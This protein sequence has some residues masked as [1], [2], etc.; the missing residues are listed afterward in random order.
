MVHNLVGISNAYVMVVY[1]VEF[2]TVIIQNNQGEDSRYF[3]EFADMW[4]LYNT[5]KEAFTEDTDYDTAFN[6]FKPLAP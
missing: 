3:A 5:F 4:E 2:K 6:F 1:D